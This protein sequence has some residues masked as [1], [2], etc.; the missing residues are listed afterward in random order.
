MIGFKEII[1]FMINQTT[2]VT[3]STFETFIK[4]KQ[5]CVVRAQVG[6]IVGFNTILKGQLEQSFK[7]KINVGVIDTSKI[8]Y[9]NKAIQHFLTISFPKIGL[10][11][12]AAIFPGY[13]LFKNGTLIAYHPGT[14]N[15][16]QMDA[17]V[18]G[19]AALFGV[20]FGLIVGIATDNARNGWQVFFEALEAPV[21]F[22]VFEFFK[23]ILGAKSHSYSQQRQQFVYGQELLNAYK[24]LQVSPDA[25]DEK[26][27]KAWKELQLKHHPDLHPNDVEAKTKFIQELNQAYE[28]IKNDRAK[29]RK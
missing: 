9:S 21:G 18:Q 19:V 29:R 4:S 25:T 8:D 27:A 3:A 24:L 6:A 11:K 5:I 28:L 10:Q 1:V 22:K 20:A 14:I 26:V 12:S 23:E 17:R 16:S 13:Y 15:P 7:D 2:E